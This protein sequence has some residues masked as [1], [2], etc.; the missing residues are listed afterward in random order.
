M[1][2]TAPP[3][4]LSDAARRFL[5]GP[6]AAA[7]R[8]RVEAGRATGARSSRST[9]RPAR[10]S[11]RSRTP[12]PRTSTRR[13]RPRARRSRT[14]SPWRKLPR[15]GARAAA[16]R[17]RR[18][19]EEHAQEL[20]ELESLDNGKPV[21]YARQI[22]IGLTIAHF[23]YFAG[24]PT[25]IEGEVIPVRRR[26]AC[27]CYTRKEPVGVAGQIIPWNFPLMMA[28][29]EAR[30]GAR[31]RLHGGAEAGR[32]DAADRAAP[33][34]ARA[35]GRLPGRRAERRHRRR[36]DRRGARRPSRRRQDL[37]HRLDR[38]RP[39]DRRQGGPRA[40]ARDARAGRQV[41]QHHP[42]RTPT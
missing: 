29:V 7:D 19:V 40:E 1:T 18:P 14:G 23:R 26:R 25:K 17:A 21:T 41:G 32:A 36:R 39:R 2:V 28:V 12:A 37:V 16:E 27:S 5:D 35:R 13:C 15:R 6:A 4:S 8:R 3:D 9:R 38:G 34:R 10:R 20:A 33:R 31:R 11:R 30:A 22:D 24:W 42:A